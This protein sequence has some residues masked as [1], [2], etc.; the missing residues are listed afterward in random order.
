M[1]FFFP[2]EKNG[3]KKQGQGLSR[4][5]AGSCDGAAVEAVWYE[6]VES[7]GEVMDEST[8]KHLGW[9]MDATAPAVG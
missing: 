5:A 4:T 1:I 6:T 7:E 2:R 8:A 9:V 3:P